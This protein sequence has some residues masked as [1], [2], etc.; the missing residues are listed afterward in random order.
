MI[1]DLILALIQI[2]S[3]LL[4]KN[5]T[6]THIP[7]LFHIIQPLQISSFI[8]EFNESQS[9]TQ[10]PY[11]KYI[12]YNQTIPNQIYIKVPLHQLLSPKYA[13][14]QIR[15][16]FEQFNHCIKQDQFQQ[17]TFYSQS[18]T[19]LSSPSQSKC[20]HSHSEE[21][22]EVVEE[23]IR[24]LLETFEI[25]EECDGVRP[26]I[27]LELKQDWYFQSRELLFMLTRL[28]QNAF[29]T[30]SITLSQ[31]FQHTR[32][33]RAP[34][35]EEHE[36]FTSKKGCFTMMLSVDRYGVKS[37][38]DV[39][40]QRLKEYLDIA[41]EKGFHVIVEMNQDIGIDYEILDCVLES[42]N[43]SISM[44]F[45]FDDLAVIKILSDPNNTSKVFLLTNAASTW[46][47]LRSYR[48]Q[49]LRKLLL[50]I[51]TSLDREASAI[52]HVLWT[53]F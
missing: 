8:Q 13:F 30:V 31:P 21:V 50:N 23:V 46:Y 53:R 41:N 33:H 20:V 44:P 5:V 29:P 9:K 25:C 47:Q 24:H 51:S 34:T 28:F 35:D 2:K 49:L 38:D 4:Y 10:M 19:T 40:I 14:N 48:A 32:N 16:S 12:Q 26:G 45:A 27:I 6:L 17:N 7:Q 11:A 39:Y 22:Q 15:N 43:A 18:S 42:K 37:D 3:T 36:E 1:S 52:A